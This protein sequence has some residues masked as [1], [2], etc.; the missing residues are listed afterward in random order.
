MITAYELHHMQK[1]RQDQMG[2]KVQL[3][4]AFIVLHR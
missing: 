4:S 3:I 1:Q 2:I